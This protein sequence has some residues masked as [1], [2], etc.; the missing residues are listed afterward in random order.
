[1]MKNKNYLCKTTNDFQQKY[2]QNPTLSSFEEWMGFDCSN[3]FTNFQ[4]ADFELGPAL[5]L[6]DDTNSNY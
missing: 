6:I 5:V 3:N 1:M 2:I 4:Q